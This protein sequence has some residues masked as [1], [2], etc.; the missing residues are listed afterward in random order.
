MKIVK[1][2]KGNLI[3]LSLVRA[4]CPGC[5]WENSH[6][7]NPESKPSLAAARDV[8]MYKHDIQRTKCISHLSFFG[9]FGKS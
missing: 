8:L 2:Q 3:E 9:G 1:Q 6:L 7:A 4:L 5:K